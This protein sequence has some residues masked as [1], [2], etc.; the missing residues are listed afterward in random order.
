MIAVYLTQALHNQYGPIVRIAPNEL[1][2]TDERAWVDIWT[3]TPAATYGTRRDPS[4]TDLIGGDMMNSN[5][6]VARVQQ[7]H[8]RMRRAF[9]PTSTKQAL[10]AQEPLIVGHI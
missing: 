5:T 1:T 7:R 2:Y 9:T 10:V 6:S 3:S 8:S 4:A